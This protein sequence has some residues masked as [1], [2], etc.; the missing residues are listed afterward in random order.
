MKKIQ[1]EESMD[2][3]KK[4]NKKRTLK[5]VEK[6]DNDDYSRFGGPDY[7]SEP[8]E[9]GQE[10]FERS[11][12]QDKSNIRIRPEGNWHHPGVSGK[13]DGGETWVNQDEYNEQTSF[14]GYGPKNYKRSDDRIY[15]EVCET[16]MKHRDVDASNIGVKVENGIVFLSGK[17]DGRSSKKIAELIIEDLPG[18]QDVRNELNVIR[19]QMSRSGPDSAV[20]EDLGIN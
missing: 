17:V 8:F 16:L 2:R 12:H 3:N 11:S 13:S 14:V 19:K 7:S 4:E 10:D 15:E 18:V 1:E 5:L 20:K 9:I 6:Y